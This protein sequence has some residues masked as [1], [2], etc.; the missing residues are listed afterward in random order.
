MWVAKQASSMV[1]PLVK[2]VVMSALAARGK[3]YVLDMG[4][5]KYGDSILCVFGDTTI[6]IDGGHRSDYAGQ[7]GFDSIPEQLSQILGVKPPFK[8][9]LLVVTHCHADHIGSLPQMV[10]SGDLVLEWALVADEK[11]GFGRAVDGGGQ[12]SFDRASDSVQRVVA[13]LR[14]EPRDD[15][16][17]A[18]LDQFLEDAVT[19]E[20]RYKDMLNTLANNG[21]KLVRY[22]RD[23][24][25]DLLEKFAGT[26]MTVLGPTQD[27]LLLCAENIAKYTKDA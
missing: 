12:D 27:H 8:I 20:Q 13:A 16:S 10:T 2:G 11:L 4:S 7:S 18:E 22:G 25:A 6:L 15:M 23:N 19:L 9:S 1:D 3:Y 17:D 24:A 5:E 26:G 14:E 21:T